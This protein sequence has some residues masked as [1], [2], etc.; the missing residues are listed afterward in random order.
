M[1][2]SAPSQAALE[3][4]RRAPRPLDRATLPREGDR[5][6][7]Y[8]VTITPAADRAW[9][10]RMLIGEMPML[11]YSHQG[12]TVLSVIHTGKWSRIEAR[13][14]GMFGRNFSIIREPDGGFV[15]ADHTDRLFYRADAEQ[16]LPVRFPQNVRASLDVSH[17]EPVEGRHTRIATLTIAGPPAMRMLVWFTND[18]ELAVFQRP[19][20][21]SVMGCPD[22]L[23]ESGLLN[24]EVLDLGV[25]LRIE[26]YSPQFGGLE[27]PLVTV[28]IDSIAFH[29]AKSEDFQQPSAYSDLRDSRRLAANL[30]P[31]GYTAPNPASLDDLRSGRSPV[32]QTPSDV[33]PVDVDP[34]TGP[35]AGGPS[36]DTL[37]VPQCLP[38][39]FGSQV[40]MVTEQSFY[41]DIQFLLNQI[42]KRLDQFQGS[43]GTL[44]VNWLEQWT[45]SKPVKDKEDGLFCVLRDRPE[46]DP[47]GTPNPGGLG[48]LD[49]LAERQVRKALING[50]LASQVTLSPVQLYY[51]TNVMG[52]P[53]AQRYAALPGGIQTQIRD[54]YL[55]ERIGK[56][57]FTYATSTSPT[58]T[59][60]GL[61]GVQLSDIEFSIAIHNT[62][63]VET[64]EI[65]NKT[66]HMVVNLPNA[67]G[68]AN[69]GRWPTGLYFLAL[70]ASGL[71]CFWVPPACAAMPYVADVGLFLLSDYAYV[72]VSLN[73]LKADITIDFK[74][75]AAQVLRPNATVKLNA[76]VNVYYMSYIPTGLHQLVSFVYSLVGSHTDLVIGEIESQ[77]QDQL[78]DLLVKT[79]DL[80]FPP[81]F[82]PVPLAGL[83]SSSDG[84]T[85][86]FLFLQA[87]LNA[88]AIGIS[89]PYITQVDPNVE[90]RLLDGRS[91]FPPLV[92]PPDSP[93][94][95]PVSR[96]YGGFLLSQ[97][98][99]NHYINALWRN[100]AFNYQLAPA[101]V[102]Q[103]ATVFKRLVSLT[104]RLQ[105]HLWPAVTPRTVF[106][107][108]GQAEQGFY[109][110]TFFDDVRLC[111]TAEGDGRSILELQFA[112]QA[113]TQIGFGAVDPSTKKLDIIRVTDTFIDLF[114]DLQRLN[115]RLI[116]PEVQDVETDG[117]VFAPLTVKS[118][119]VLE[120]AMLM[121]LRF[122]LA[123]RD[124]SAIPSTA[125][126]P[127]F[128]QYPIPGATIDMHLTPFRGNLYGWVLLTGTGP[129]HGLL[130]FFPNGTLD[131]SRMDCNQ[132]QAVRKTI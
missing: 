27:H 103:V 110:T 10:L 111:I 44:T 58:T 123:A 88:P 80:S 107:P 130:A 29:G 41:S 116:H 98:F 68:A 124:D 30:E 55:N 15:F 26:T 53:P 62:E 120:P 28:T 115:V 75:D 83:T 87:G 126:N 9:A 129:S 7:H 3:R 21:C 1:V 13:E 91:N 6:L 72:R 66:I 106:T 11:D 65:L 60:H 64:L 49:K 16:A 78:N 36:T 74:P 90:K 104:G 2:L 77:A 59:F 85:H 86:D 34:N 43:E 95:F 48:L 84:A 132:G 46:D 112:A 89:A 24:R 40:A 76:D 97:N 12:P 119:S 31:H 94:G 61:V 82:G 96:R 100:G 113:F 67:S 70:G 73:N 33:N 39:T 52:R 35:P 42:F 32:G 38:A 22:A 18:P 114:F 101:E 125:G 47:P 108:R 4:I 25:P 45:N 102:I 63:P 118:A 50:T 51:V 71:L 81:K 20:F 19:I 93:T 54:L 69:I 37:R 131:V 127:L 23:A 17:G 128:H 79:L 121:A 8:R 99:I 105:M 56:F 117:P 122:A 57:S 14:P 5:A 109:A 92:D